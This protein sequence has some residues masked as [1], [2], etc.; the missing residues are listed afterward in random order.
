MLKPLLAQLSLSAFVLCYGCSQK[1]GD[2]TYTCSKGGLLDSYCEA[3]LA[4]P[5]VL[6]SIDGGSPELFFQFEGGGGA[7]PIQGK[8]AN[9]ELILFGINEEYA[10]AVLAADIVFLADRAERSWEMDGP[11]SLADAKRL[12]G[13]NWPDMKQV[14]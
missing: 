2:F 13:E 1:V 3:K 7:S 11:Y 14:Q 5:Y 8:Y 6:A 12:L 4:G 9:A 10:V